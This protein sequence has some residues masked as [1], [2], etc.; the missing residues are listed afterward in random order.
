MAWIVGTGLTP[1]GRHA[2]SNSLDLMA[3]AAAD[4]LADAQLERDDID[5]LL[6]GY[7]TT[8]PHI[9]LATVFAEYF[10]LAPAYA[11]AVQVGGATGLAMAMLA[12]ALIVAG[13]ARN[14][15]IVA[16]ENRLTGQS[17]DSA[18]GALAQVGHPQWEVPLGGSVPAYYALV[19]SAYM[20]EFGIGSDQLAALAVLMR[21]N[22]CN[23]PGAHLR[24][25]LSI[26]DAMNTRLIA[27]PLRLSDCCPISDGAAA[28]VISADPAGAARIRIRGGGQAH[29]HQ[30]L[31]AAKSL[32]QFG[33][34]LSVRRAEAA[35]GLT[36]TDIDYAAIYDSFTI[37][38]Q[39][40]LEE[41]GLAPLGRAGIWAAEGR[42]AANGALP[43]NTHGGLLS[44][45]HCG[46]AGGM[47]HLI[48]ATRQMKGQAGTRQINQPSLALVHGE[49]GVMSSHVSLFLERTR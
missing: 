14:I 40:L 20:D 4:A 17:R 22:A 24:D 45:G 21:T 23:C 26:D 18:V 29:L 47:A 30:H 39:I 31:S 37:T 1:F 13:M 16:G 8:H 25:P 35:S 49:G 41:I 27:D 9:M 32:T 46:V 38:L 28:L 36:R 48:E 15:L 11:H 6:C 5:G 33:A 7:T 34:D 19:A 42:F 10:G 12:Q 43:L 3:V 44:Y 2:G